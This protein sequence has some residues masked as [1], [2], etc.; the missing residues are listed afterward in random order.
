[1][2]GYDREDKAINKETIRI[3]EREDCRYER[4]KD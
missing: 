3:C 1:M 2:L 4:E